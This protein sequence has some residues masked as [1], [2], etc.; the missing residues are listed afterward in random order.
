[1]N[2]ATL[3]QWMQHRGQFRVEHEDDDTAVVY[4]YDAI[5]WFAINAGDFVPEIAALKVSRIRLHINSP[6]GDVF[7]AVA[8]YT[9]LKDHPAEVETRIDGIAASAASFIAQA[10]DRIVMA[11]HA[12]MMIHDPWGITIGDAASHRK[13][14][15]VLDK[16]GDNIARIYAGRAGGSVREWRD[17]ML[18]ENWYDDHEAVEAGLAD[19]V[20]GT[21]EAVENRFDL[22]MYQNVPERYRE[23][24]S[25][26][27]EPDKREI[28]QALREAGLSR[29]AAA[30]VVASGWNAIQRSPREA[31]E[32]RA[33]DGVLGRMTGAEND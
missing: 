30:A 27:R 16:L 20:A 22:S 23:P 3:R 29:S 24:A 14:A 15:D 28:E 7:D 26:G 21:K 33:L 4:L 10:G 6:G 8:I 18:D 1:M 32:L 31:A 2:E 13:Q 19:E 9:A 11:R 25:N 12:T 17:R 5:G